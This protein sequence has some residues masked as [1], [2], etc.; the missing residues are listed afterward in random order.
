MKV[1]VAHNLYASAQPSGENAVVAAEIAALEAAGV[2]VIPYLRSSDEIATMPLS[3]R[4][5]LPLSPIY[6]GRAQREVAELLATQRPDVLHLHNPYPLLSPWLVR[7][8]HGAGVPV[9][10]TVHNFRHECVSGVF[11]R[12]GQP[13]YACQGKRLSGPALRGRCYR[14]SLP[15]TAAMVAALGVHRRTFLQVDRFIA[16]SPRIVSFLRGLGARGSQI[17]LRPNPVADPGLPEAIGEGFLFAGRLSAEKGVSLLLDAWRRSPEGTHGRLVI[18]GDG[19]LRAEVQALAA[20]RIDL[21]YV[22][23]LDPV[24]VRSAIRS[25]AV[26]VVPSV[27]DDVLPTVAIEALAHGRP[28]LA[29]EMGG[30]PWIVRGDGQAPAAGWLVRP[31]TPSLAAGLAEAKAT[32]R[33]VAPHARA[34]YERDFT[35][36]LQTERLLSI[37]REVSG[38]L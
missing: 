5:S 14:G 7:T 20:Q 30:L 25:C 10:Q 1:V 37:Y 6:A 22:G 38:R 13:C 21:T 27:W 15:Q 4:A 26:V 36:K 35:P 8:A 29:T 28:V 9:V 24:Q 11:F 31:D 34:R 2:T 32:A 16:L 19:P 18:A 12:D 3:Q 17:A 33:A 23:R